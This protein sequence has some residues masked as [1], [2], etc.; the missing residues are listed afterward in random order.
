MQ[1]LGGLLQEHLRRYPLMAL[2]DAYKLLHQAALGPA[3]LVAAGPALEWLAAEA[4]ALEPG[5]ADPLVDPVSPD[6]DLCRVH[7]RAWVAADLPLPPLAAALVQTAAGTVPDPKRMARFCDCLAGLCQE[8]LPLQG[9]EQAAAW[10]QDRAA[11][12][13]PAAHHGDAYRR[14]YRPAYRVVSLAR[15]REEITL[16]AATPG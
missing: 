14:A 12:G 16:P 8:G 5:P 7:L 15:L 11:A 3:H 1:F 10:L 9:A 4:A 13:F 2:V 6:G